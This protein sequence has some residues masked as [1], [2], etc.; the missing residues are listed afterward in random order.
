MGV[1]IAFTIFFFITAVACITVMCFGCKREEIQSPG[2]MVV[3]AVT[4]VP[5]QV[6]T[7]TMGVTAPFEGEKRVAV[8]PPNP[9]S[10]S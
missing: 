1:G 5:G 2:G 10:S 3:K 8:Q 7:L 6:Y 4:G 9:Y